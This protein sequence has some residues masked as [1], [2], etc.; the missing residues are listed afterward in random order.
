MVA[1]AKEGAPPRRDGWL[2]RKGTIGEITVG[3]LIAGHNRTDVWE[4]LDTK[5]P[6]QYEFGHTGWMLLVNR[7]TGEQMAVPPRNKTYEC[8]FLMK[9][10]EEVPPPYTPPSDFEEKVQLLRDILGAV[11]LANIDNA[12]G[13]ITCPDYDGSFVTMSGEKA[14]RGAEF[15]DHLRI[16]HG[17]DTTA[18]EVLPREE[19][20]AAKT[21]AHGRAHN[22]EHPQI[23]K[24]GVPHRH[25]PERHGWKS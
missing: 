15:F 10:D 14:P 22:P 19:Q 8:V 2:E 5:T 7:T 24:G 12:T 1:P 21:T 23:G 13:E 11:E 16:M 18:L 6:E 4:V 20:A 17:M 9:S 25:V 3:S